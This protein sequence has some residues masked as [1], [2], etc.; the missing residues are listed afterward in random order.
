MCF[1]PQRRALFLHLNF[2]K[3]SEH[4]LFVHFWLLKCAS[5]QN[6][7]H[8]FDIA[9]SKSGPELT[10]L[11]HFDFQMCFTPQRRA[12]FSSLIWPN[13]S[14][15]AALASLLF[16]HPKPQII[17][18]TQWI[19]T[20]LP[21]RASASSFFSLFLFSDLLSSFH[22]LS[23]SFHICFSICPLSGSFTF[24]LPSNIWNSRV[25]YIHARIH[26]AIF[27]ERLQAQ[28][29]YHTAVYGTGT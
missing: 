11:V 3:W 12:I 4:G 16:D 13:G 7:V 29:Q 14:A 9:T 1:T 8:F 6:C 24:K 21:F 5:R 19:T 10:C 18:K 25:K 26:P 2:Q 22:L 15:P 27:I 17:G 28:P 20:V 23:D